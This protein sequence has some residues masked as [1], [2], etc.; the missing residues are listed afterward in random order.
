M[1]YCDT[2]LVDEGV[3]EL[4]PPWHW[5]IKVFSRFAVLARLAN[6]SWPYHLVFQ[7]RPFTRNLT[8]TKQRVAAA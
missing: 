6:L 5:G 7:L 8:P 3:L 4:V 2:R 1:V